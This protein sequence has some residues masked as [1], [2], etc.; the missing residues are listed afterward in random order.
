MSREG[1]RERESSRLER[2]PEP[3]RTDMKRREEENQE[4]CRTLAAEV[5]KPLRKAASKPASLM[6]LALLSLRQRF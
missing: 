6:S 1:G 5:V 2:V 4:L 3:H